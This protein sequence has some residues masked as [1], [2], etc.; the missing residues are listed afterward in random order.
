MNG[1]AANRLFVFLMLDD[2]TGAI[3]FVGRVVNPNRLFARSI[4]WGGVA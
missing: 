4:I 1:Y 3:L 2:V